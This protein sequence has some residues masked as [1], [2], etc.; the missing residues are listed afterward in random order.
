MNVH[1]L[2]PCIFH[3][4]CICCN[5]FQNFLVGPTETVFF[6]NHI[7]LLLW[8]RSPCIPL[9]KILKDD[10]FVVPLTPVWKITFCLTV[11]WDFCVLNGSCSFCWLY[12]NP[13]KLPLQQAISFYITIMLISMLE[14]WSI[15]FMTIGKHSSSEHRSFC[16]CSFY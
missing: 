6:W 13:M 12:S 15:T 14:L 7:W 1:G 8:I 3:E 5:L 2:C 4:M 9:W 16:F 10:V 11:F